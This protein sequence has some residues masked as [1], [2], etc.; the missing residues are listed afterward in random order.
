MAEG[1]MNQPDRDWGGPYLQAAFFCE[2]LLQE[3]DGVLSA[4]R[5]VDHVTAQVAEPESSDRVATVPVRLTLLVSFKTGRTRGTRDLTVV[6]VPPDGPSP[7]WPS[8]DYTQ[9]ILFEGPDDRGD[10]IIMP[11][12]MSADRAGI[13]WFDVYLDNQ[14]LTRVPL[15]VE[16]PKQTPGPDPR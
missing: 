1:A 16:I 11:I 3:V 7:A 13:Y 10:T 4:I 12:A 6:L 5:M 8:Q 15:R 14:L 9:T 2:R